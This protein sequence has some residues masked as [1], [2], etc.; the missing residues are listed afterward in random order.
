MSEQRLPN[1]V[2]L[3]V[4]FRSPAEQ[5]QW[6][7]ENLPLSATTMPPMLSHIPTLT[8]ATEI[9]KR[10]QQTRELIRLGQLLRADLGLTRSPCSRL[11]LQ[12]SVVSASVSWSSI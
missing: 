3:R 6:E 5:V 11:S 9:Q 10:I 8:N 4:R 1:K 12:L 7:R 2:P